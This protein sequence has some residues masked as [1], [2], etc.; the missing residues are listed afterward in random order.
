MIY[1]LKVINHQNIPDEGGAILIC[2]H[3]S[4]VDWII[5]SAAVK[6]PLR[7]VFYY[8]FMKI[9]FMSWFFK[10]GKGIPI[11]GK[12]EDPLILEQAWKKIEQE[13]RAGELVCI[14]PEGYITRDGK[15]DGFRPGIEKML[16]LVQVPVIPMTTKGLWGS[17]FSRK[18]N[19]R[20]LSKP[21]LIF[22]RW[23]SKIELEIYEAWDP[24]DVTA[25]KL[26][27]FTKSKLTE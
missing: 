9:P 21:S 7:Y 6:R 17:F 5:I 23:F 27:E 4:F 14:F 24:K 20:A 3:V 22:S 15:L 16:E 12:N 18:Y 11:A 8:K 1:R 19:G 25:K 10:G 2:N 26:E 13:L